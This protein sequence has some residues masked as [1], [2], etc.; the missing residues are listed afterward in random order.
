M[1]HVSRM[2]TSPVA[3]AQVNG[4]A[5]AAKGV[6]TSHYYMY[7]IVASSFD[8]CVHLRFVTSVRVVCI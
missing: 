3:Y 4:L 5:L 8:R 1:R 6:N 2:R 7:E